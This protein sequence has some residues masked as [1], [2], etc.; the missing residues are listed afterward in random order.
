M[1]TGRMAKWQMIF[2]EFDIIFTTQKAIK[3]QA[4][5]DHLDEN[6]RENDYQPLYTYFP[7]EEILYISASEYMSKQYLGWRLFFNGA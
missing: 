5:A 7:D 1:P 6:L 3:G 2:L 4:I